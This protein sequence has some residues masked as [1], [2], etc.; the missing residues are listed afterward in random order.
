MP[1][2]KDLWTYGNIVVP[3]E[4]S[5]LTEDRVFM[6]TKMH[7]SNKDRATP[8]FVTHAYGQPVAPASAQ[9]ATFQHVKVTPEIHASRK[10]V[11]AIQGK[12]RTWFCGSYLQGL[13]LQENAI[14]T[15]LKVANSIMAGVT[16]YPISKV[17]KP[18]LAETND[19]PLFLLECKTIFD[20]LEYHL[21][22][23]PEFPLFKWVNDKGAEEE[24]L[25]SKELYD[26][27]GAVAA[28]LQSL[29][30]KP[31]DCVMVIY[32]PSLEFVT[33]FFGC[34]RL[35]A[36]P[37]PTA[38]PTSDESIPILAH[39]IQVSGAK[40]GLVSKDLMHSPL[41]QM[42]TQVSWHEIS[43]QRK[44][45]AMFQTQ[46]RPSPSDLAWIQFTSGST[47]DPKGVMIT[48][49][50]VMHQLELVRCEMNYRPRSTGVS[51]VPHYHDLGLVSVILSGVYVGGTSV[52][53]SPFTF[54]QNPALYLDLLHKYEASFIGGPD[55][56]YRLLVKKTTPEQRKKWD[57]SNLEIVMSAGD[58]VNPETIAMF[59]DAFEPCGVNR[60]CFKNGYGLA[61]H[62]C[63][64]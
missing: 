31:K 38:P 30:V 25:S 51:W 15:G 24:T 32:M 53:M 10:Q 44:S 28:Y 18:W 52:M 34:L 47:S 26:Q 37:V 39:V 2:N 43:Q 13:T 27:A 42:L 17:P 19:K 48:H 5:A 56:S 1:K 49:G 16:E 40:F 14:V 64:K 55:F 20:S 60:N 62:V 22:D 3:T 41:P 54:V 9:R 61:E 12:N 7:L 59:L 29:G 21:R 4:Q 11:K 33:A 50:N 57:L 23:K 35:G 63:G 45:G 58:V 46:H 6:A 8:V 36:I